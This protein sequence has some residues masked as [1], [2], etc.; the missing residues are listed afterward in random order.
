[1]DWNSETSYFADSLDNYLILFDECQSSANFRDLSEAAQLDMAGT[2]ALTPRTHVPM[3]SFGQKQ[4]L[5][6]FMEAA[7]A[8]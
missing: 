7:V 2:R 4:D 1:M 5:W 3:V 6:P 8:T